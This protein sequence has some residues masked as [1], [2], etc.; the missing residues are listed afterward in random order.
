MECWGIGRPAHTH[1]QLKFVIQ[2]WCDH[3]VHRWSP[4]EQGDLPT[5]MPAH[6]HDFRGGV[7]VGCTGGALG[8]REACPC[9]FPARIHEFRDGVIMGCSGGVL[10]NRE[11][12]PHS[13]PAHIHEFRGGKIVA[14]RQH[15]WLTLAPWNFSLFPLCSLVLSGSKLLRQSPVRLRILKD[16]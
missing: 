6:I 13:F 10:G 11:A 12:C 8:N 3:G 7:I 9:S 1:S 15:P 5:V 14:L 2:G 16:R 4:G